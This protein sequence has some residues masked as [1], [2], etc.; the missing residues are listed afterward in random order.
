MLFE[1]WPLRRGRTKSEFE[2]PL[3]AFITPCEAEAGVH[4]TARQINVSA[5]V[6]LMG[7]FAVAS[8]IHHRHGG[9]GPEPGGRRIW[10]GIWQQPEQRQSR[11]VIPYRHPPKF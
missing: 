9:I 7:R 4:R 11:P 8:H 2:R 5:V 10:R 3:V 6:E 1:H